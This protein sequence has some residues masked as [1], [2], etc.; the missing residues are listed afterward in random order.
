MVE[1]GV[2]P[3]A[4]SLDEVSDLDIQGQEAREAGGDITAQQ[5]PGKARDQPAEKTGSQASGDSR[6]SGQTGFGRVG[7]AKAASPSMDAKANE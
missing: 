4:P 7:S 6:V 5:E 1:A 2:R 3:G